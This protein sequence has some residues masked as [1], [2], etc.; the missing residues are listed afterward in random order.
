MV[1]SHSDGGSE[2]RREAGGV[3]RGD[4]GWAPDAQVQNRYENTINMQLVT[5]KKHQLH[6]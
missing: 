1:Y 5:A 2:G 4:V 6:V 3:A